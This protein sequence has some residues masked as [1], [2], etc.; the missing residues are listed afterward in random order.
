VLRLEAI[1]IAC[2]VAAQFLS[3]LLALRLIGLTKRSV[4]WLSIAAAITLMAFRR[5]ESLLALLSGDPSFTPNLLFEVNG[6]V[7]SL[8][9]LVGMYLIRPIF[10]ALTRSEVHQR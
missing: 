6:L 8:L 9:M 5:L 7:I 10:S 4:A 1:V 2:A 3:A